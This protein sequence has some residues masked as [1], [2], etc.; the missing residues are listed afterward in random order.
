[1]T[2][3]VSAP[4]TLYFFFQPGCAA[5]AVAKPEL[6][7]FRKLHPEAII[8]MCNVSS[9]KDWSLESGNPEKP[10]KPRATP[11]YA[12][13]H[14]GNLLDHHEGKLTRVQLEKFVKEALAEVEE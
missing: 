3:P 8:L 6:E 12:V 13:T 4:Y 9:H 5:C 14:F 10:F 7:G 2:N 1:M 11:T